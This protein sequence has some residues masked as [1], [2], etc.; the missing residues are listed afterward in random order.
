M[1]S[2]SMPLKSAL[3]MATIVEFGTNHLNFSLLKIS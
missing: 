3:K 1:K 2:G